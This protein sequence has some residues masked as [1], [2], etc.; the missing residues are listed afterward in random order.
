MK[1]QFIIDASPL[2][3]PPTAKGQ[4]TRDPVNIYKLNQKNREEMTTEE[5]EAAMTDAL[6]HLLLELKVLN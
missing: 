5:I 1:V 3:I 6:L 4:R 2:T